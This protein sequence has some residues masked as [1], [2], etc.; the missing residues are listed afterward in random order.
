MYCNHCGS[1]IADQAAIC[2]KCGV[3]TGRGNASG[4]QP[5]SRVLYVVLAL[6]FGCL[7]VHNFVVGYTGRGVAQLLISVCTLFFGACFVAIWALVEAFTVKEDANGIP[8]S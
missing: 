4:K 1:Q 8:F 7:G 6:L 2:V 3:A 5:T